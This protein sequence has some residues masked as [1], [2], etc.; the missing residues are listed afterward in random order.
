MYNEQL[1]KEIVEVN[2]LFLDPNNPRFWSEQS[3]NIPLIR[4]NYSGLNPSFKRVL[5]CA[6]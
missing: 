5:F 6:C 3:R 2:N 4:G 1:K